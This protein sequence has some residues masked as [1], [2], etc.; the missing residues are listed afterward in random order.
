MSLKSKPMDI[1]VLEIHLNKQINLHQ[2]VSLVFLYLSFHFDRHDM[3]RQ[4]FVRLFKELSELENN[5]SQKLI[6]FL[7]LR[8]G[9][10]A[11]GQVMAPIMQDWCSTSLALSTAEMCLKRTFNALLELHIYA[12]EHGDYHA[13]N[14]LKTKIIDEEEEAMAKASALFKTEKKNHAIFGSNTMA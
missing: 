8:G 3:A 1:K 2:H 13:A 5:F 6:E 12:F 4:E 9:K 10:V 14:F 7:N 11:F